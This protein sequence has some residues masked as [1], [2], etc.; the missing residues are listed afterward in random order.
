M[1]T[2][3]TDIFELAKFIFANRLNEAGRRSAVSRA[4]YAAW[5]STKDIFGMPVD[6]EDGETTHKAVIRSAA[7][8]AKAPGPAR[9]EAAKI[10]SQLDVLRRLRNRADYKLEQEFE[11]NNCADCL[12]RVTRVIELCEEAKAKLSSL[13][14]KTSLLP[15]D[16]KPPPP[17]GPR[18]T[19]KRVK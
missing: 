16:E 14:A 9:E 13:A 3:P 15:A 18:P 19:L 7:A 4:Y 6:S 10:A 5:H 12:E 11:K 2:H 1:S 8:R 17:S